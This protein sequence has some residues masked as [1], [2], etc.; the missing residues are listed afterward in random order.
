MRRLGKPKAGFTL[1]EL[2][3][4]VAVLALIAGFSLNTFSKV[5]D[6][7]DQRT[8]GLENKRDSAISRIEEAKF[9]RR[10]TN[11]TNSANIIS[12]NNRNAHQ[13]R[14]SNN[15]DYRDDDD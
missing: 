7:S 11:Y 9:G 10:N 5:K 6:S 3:V 1:M 12:S 15:D 2:M 8:A 13:Y 14:S 4:V